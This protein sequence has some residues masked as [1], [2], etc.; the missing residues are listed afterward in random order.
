MEGAALF[1]DRAILGGL[2]DRSGVLVDGSEEE[3]RQAVRKVLGQMQ[4]RRFVLGADCTLP[5]E[6]DYNRIRT[7]VEAVK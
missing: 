4:G 5:T 2:D 6:I 3:I 1:K 7:A